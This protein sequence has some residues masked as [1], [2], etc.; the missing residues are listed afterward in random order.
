MLIA[1]LL[2]SKAQKKALLLQCLFSGKSSIQ[3]AFISFSHNH[4]SDL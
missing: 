4:R 3:I 2:D 1:T